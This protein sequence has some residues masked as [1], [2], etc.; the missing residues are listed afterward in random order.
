MKATVAERAEKLRDWAWEQRQIEEEAYLRGT[1]EHGVTQSSER[2]ERLAE[3]LDWRALSAEERRRQLHWE[4]RYTIENYGYSTEDAKASVLAAYHKFPP[5]DVLIEE[6][7][8]HI[9][10]FKA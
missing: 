10:E 3:N 4:I 7:E 9:A 2:S 5:G 6:A 1:Y 8:E